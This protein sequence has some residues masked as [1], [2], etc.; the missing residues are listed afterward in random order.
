MN[1]DKFTEK[2]QQAITAAQEIAFV[3]WSSAS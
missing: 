1:I 2:S 3:V